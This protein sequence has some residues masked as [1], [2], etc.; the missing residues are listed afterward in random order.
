MECMEEL[1][2]KL[3]Q[4]SLIKNKYY[5]GRVSDKNRIV[6]E[7][8]KWQSSIVKVVAGVYSEHIRMNQMQT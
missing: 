2:T 8:N 4:E 1:K 6:C 7:N 5:I 3:S